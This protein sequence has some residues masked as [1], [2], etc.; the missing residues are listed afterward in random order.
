MGKLARRTMLGSCA[1]LLVEG[2]RLWGA[3][4]KVASLST[5][6]VAWWPF[7]E[8]EGTIARD[9]GPAQYSAHLEGAAAF[10]PGRIGNAIS[11]DGKTA[12]LRVPGFKGIGGSRP[13]SIAAWIRT[14]QAVGEIVSWGSNEPGKMWIFGF[15]RGRIGV[16]PRG[17]YLYM[18]QAVHDD[19]W[20]HVAAVMEEG[21]PPN[22]YDHVRLYLDGSPAEIH[23]I[24][25]LDLWPIDTG[26]DLEV[27]IGRRFA[28]LID[29]LRIY[30]RAL[31]DEEVYALWKMRVGDE[32]AP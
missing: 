11:L 12:M 19:K 14:R 27:V 5:D 10:A 8:N 24:G 1:V 18:Q 25:L 15:I 28:G 6:L 9:Q 3:E 30:G 7:D 22:L 13:R 26:S 31:T 23:D 16:T 29:D 4:E 2:T 21:S 32:K 17:G 20:H